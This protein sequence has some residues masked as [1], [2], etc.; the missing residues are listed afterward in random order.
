MRAGLTLIVVVVACGV[1]ALGA[2]YGVGEHRASER[3]YQTLKAELDDLRE[4]PQRSVEQ[5]LQP[6]V[7][8]DAKKPE[9]HRIAG[10]NEEE[11]E[12]VP[13]TDSPAPAQISPEEFRA[14][15][16]DALRSS[17]TMEQKDPAWSGDTE[18]KVAAKFSNKLPEGSQVQKVECRSSMCIIQ[19]RH[20]TLQD[21][22]A[23][24]DATLMHP[25]DD[26]RPWGPS[27]ALVETEGESGELSVVVA[28]ARAGHELP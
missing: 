27:E 22:R 11:E 2:F 8:Q 9:E 28:L 17:F 15:R 24:V 26:A 13:K 25:D 20:K 4:T 23:F 1:G 18:K 6:Q 14:A 10:R 16:S 12:P 19:M 5:I 7:V 21:F 3:R